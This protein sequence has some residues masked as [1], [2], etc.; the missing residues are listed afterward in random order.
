MLTQFAD[1]A[2][3]GSVALASEAVRRLD[4]RCGCRYFGFTCARGGL[5]R[6]QSQDS[7]FKKYG[8]QGAA[9]HP[10]AGRQGTGE[11]SKERVGRHEFSPLLVGRDSI[12]G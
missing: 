2:R 12:G 5:E 7:R 8:K 10:P 9:R 4:G 6:P 1:V 3:S 11:S